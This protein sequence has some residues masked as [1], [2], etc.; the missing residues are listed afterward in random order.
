[1]HPN[2][3]KVSARESQNLLNTI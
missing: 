2:S 3:Q 1:M